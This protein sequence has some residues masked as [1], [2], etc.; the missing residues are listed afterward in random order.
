ME[1]SSRVSDSVGFQIDSIKDFP[2]LHG[3][4]TT[5]MK[6]VADSEKHL[7]VDAIVDDRSDVSDDCSN[8][9][10]ISSEII[11]RNN[12]ELE[13]CRTYLKDLLSNETMA[14]D[15]L[16]DTQQ[17]GI[18]GVSEKGRQEVLM[19][20]REFNSFFGFA[21]GTFAAASTL[22][23]RM[24]SVTRVKPEHGDIVGIGCLLIAAKQNEPKEIVPTVLQICETCNG[25]F[26]NAEIERIEEIINKRLYQK[27]NGRVVITLD[28]LDEFV[29]F[30][31]VTGAPSEVS[32]AEFEAAVTNVMN[33]S[34]Y[35]YELMS[36]R[37]SVLSLAVLDGELEHI[38][39]GDA[40][41]RIVND[42]MELME[43]PSWDLR[44]CTKCLS[45]CLGSMCKDAR[46]KDAAK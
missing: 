5:S 11:Q 43:I 29:H 23:D 6:S 2:A 26:S 31:V 10:E 8:D 40:R 22:F 27:F 35:H 21:P 7:E 45:R 15:F 19:W 17:G 36:Y 41:R 28:Y 33:S 32:T 39:S 9:S 20:I 44:N 4:G 18:G 24:L 1:V 14:P 30:A 34:T 46:T 38:A 37:P 13:E 3:D 12:S 16:E 25:R 42:L